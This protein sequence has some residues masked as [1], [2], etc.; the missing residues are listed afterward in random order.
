LACYLAA[1]D[2]YIDKTELELINRI[3]N[4]W[5]IDPTISDP[6]FLLAKI[7]ADAVR[8]QA[9]KNEQKASISRSAI[10]LRG[11]DSIFSS[12]LVNI[13][14]NTVGSGD[15]KDRVKDYRTQAL[16]SG[17]E[18]EDI[19]NTCRTIGEEDIAVADQCL[20]KTER[21]LIELEVGLGKAIEKTTQKIGNVSAGSARE[22]LEH[23][24]KDRDTLNTETAY[25]LRKIID[26]Q[27][28]KRRAINFFTISFMGKSKA[29][30]STL[31]AIM[32]GNGWDAIGVGKQNTTRLNRVYEWHNIRIVDTPG[33][34]APDGAEYQKIAESII[35]ESDLMCFVVT[36]NN[37]QKAEFEFLKRLKEKGKPLLVLMNVH[38]NLANETRLRRFLENPNDIFSDEKEKLGGHF[39]RIRRDAQE[40]Y[41]TSEFPIIPV[42]LMAA[43]LARQENDKE[44]SIALMKASRLQN[45]MDA[46]RLSL[47][48][49]G[50]IRRSQNL[51]GS[52][53]ADIE[54]PL[55]WLKERGCY[56]KSI[57]NIM[58]ERK[59]EAR[60]NIS[61]AE[62]ANR[63]KLETNVQRCIEDLR[64]LVPDFA[65]TYWDSSE[66]T[67]NSSWMKLVK[68]AGFEAGLK[69]TVTST[70]TNFSSDVKEILEEIGRDIQLT[71]QLSSEGFRLFEQDS[72]EFGHKATKWG[73]NILGAV[74]S[75]SWFIPPLYPFALVI[76]LV[77]VVFGFLSSFFESK[78][79]KKRKAVAK[80]SE[81][82]EAQID[83]QEKDITLSVI[84]S[85][86]DQCDSTT[87]S[88]EEYF[89]NIIT[90]SKN[91]AHV[92]DKCISLIE[93][94][95]DE[96]N[97]CFASR[98]LDFAE[99][100]TR[101][102]DVKTVRQRIHQVERQ[103]GHS[104][105]ITL[106]N[107]IK[108]L[109]IARLEKTLQEKITIII[110]GNQT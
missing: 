31:H 110:K 102:L 88:V 38:E 47:I 71:S 84:K 37:Q 95:R 77:G 12:R 72:S 58:G 69:A 59:S 11:V 10:M 109:D 101:K 73:G 4:T 15:F 68:T 32:T 22:V 8:Q 61:K 14:V 97:I 106:N 29:G 108:K 100:R 1:I 91:I 56:Y 55:I 75:V 46:I 36:N 45:F 3:T 16:L 25:Q 103:V 79:S 76:T 7:E 65:D 19:I 13:V 83:K 20:A 60:D 53:V 70:A 41:G 51:L 52:T 78:A 94:E 104:L 105:E 40:Y 85:F 18:Y 42:Q 26:L 39:D 64:T 74:G 89:Q 34:A 2:G 62:I 48:S 44:K 96:M 66:S 93:A 33:I 27:D 24:K 67:L 28:K 99:G 6:I 90:G 87:Q 80:I 23:L 21:A 57:V 54:L 17:S 82:L 5:G 50:A 30:K 43:R 86:N 107:P 49:E 92:L 35:D 63:K 9:K 98:A 81:T